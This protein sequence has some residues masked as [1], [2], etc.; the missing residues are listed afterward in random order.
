MVIEEP[1]R[2][3]LALVGLT[4][5][6]DV[7]FILL[8]FFML[9]T[10]FLDWRA[11]SLAFPPPSESSAN[12]E[13]DTLVV[14]LMGDGAIVFAGEAVT[15]GQLEAYFREGLREDADRPVSVRM[16]AEVP[17]QRVMLVVDAAT[18]A[19]AGNLRLERGEG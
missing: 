14:H 11:T 15:A 12:R 17:L 7:V 19:G 9:A 3:R 4:P 6:I 1:R 13:P 18:A 2:R 16:E 8:V 10:S 5:L